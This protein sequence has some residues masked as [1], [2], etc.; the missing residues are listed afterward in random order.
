MA[1]SVAVAVVVVVGGVAVVVASCFKKDMRRKR[2]RCATDISVYR[3]HKQGEIIFQQDSSSQS[4]IDSTTAK[5][6]SKTQKDHDQ[7]SET[8]SKHMK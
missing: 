1:V 6:T 3:T 5:Q 2:E 4:Q 7:Q 8:K